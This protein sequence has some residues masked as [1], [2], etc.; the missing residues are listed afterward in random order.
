MTPRGQY[1]LSILGSRLLRLFLITPSIK[2]IP[3]VYP[4]TQSPGNIPQTTSFIL[5]G[6]C[7]SSSWFC[8]PG[9]QRVG[10]CDLSS[11]VNTRLLGP[12]SH[13]VFTRPLRLFSPR[14]LTLAMCPRSPRVFTHS[15]RGISTSPTRH[16]VPPSTC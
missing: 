9:G 1:M 4:M 2:C 13:Q 3:Q 14:V 8:F 5:V 7:T 10:A 11:Q 16:L 12:Y 6:L 15:L